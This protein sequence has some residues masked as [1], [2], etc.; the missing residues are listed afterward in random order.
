MM[1]RKGKKETRGEEDNHCVGREAIMVVIR[2]GEAL[3]ER[4]RIAKE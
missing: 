2:I 3:E 1:V 4:K